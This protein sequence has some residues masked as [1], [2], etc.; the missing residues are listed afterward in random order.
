MH[1][2]FTENTMKIKAFFV[3][4]NIEVKIKSDKELCKLCEKT[5]CSL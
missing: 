4:K 5:Q 3:I 1:G 2:N